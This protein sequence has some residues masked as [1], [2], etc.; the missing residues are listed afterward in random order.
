MIT[1]GE[2]KETVVDLGYE[3][4]DVVNPDEEYGRIVASAANRALSL[5]YITVIVPLRSYFEGSP[6]GFEKIDEETTDE[7]YVIP[8]PYICEPLLP[9]LTAHYVWLDDDLTKA[10][11]YWNE[12]DDIKTQ[13]INNLS[14]Q[15]R[16]VGG[17]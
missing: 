8:I 17:F 3:E 7:D 10:T 15:A 16:I 9:L 1:W 13:I 4:D 11:I 6:E 14:R 12:Y 5:I 2:L